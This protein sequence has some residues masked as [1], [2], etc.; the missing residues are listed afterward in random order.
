MLL[1]DVYSLKKTIS[2]S[3]IDTQYMYRHINQERKKTTVNERGFVERSNMAN[4][5]Q[6]CQLS[7]TV[8]NDRFALNPRCAVDRIG[9][10]IK[11][12]LYLMI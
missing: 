11:D 5:L 6:I 8:E 4:V 7:K 9:S 1:E 10:M 3:E 2:S 12:N